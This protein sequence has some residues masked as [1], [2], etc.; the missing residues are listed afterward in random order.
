MGEHTFNAGQVYFPCGTP[1]PDDVI[2]GRVDLDSSVRRELKE[3]TGLDMD[4]FTVEPSWT[5]VIDGTLIAQ[6]KVM[7]SALRADE[8]RTRILGN[9]ASQQQPELADI[10]IVRGPA[11]VDPAMRSFIKAFLFHHFSGR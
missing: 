11:D 7:R 8:L 4:E 1:D 5:A 10:C 3:E 9:L 2:E 6:I